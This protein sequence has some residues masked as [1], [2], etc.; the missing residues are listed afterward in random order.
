M[1]DKP[2]EHSPGQKNGFEPAFPEPIAFNPNGEATT[3]A[4]YG[5]SQGL[6]KRE[7]FAM[8]VAQGIWSDHTTTNILSEGPVNIAELCKRIANTATHQADALLEELAK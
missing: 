2:K 4:A 3:A 7:L 6:T 5:F 8:S 1:S